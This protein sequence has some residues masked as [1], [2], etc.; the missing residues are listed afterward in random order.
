MTNFIKRVNR[1]RKKR[2]FDNMKYIYVLAVDN[3][4]RPHFHILMSGDGVDR[5]ELEAMWGKCKRPNTRRVKPDEDFG[6]TGLA[7]YISQNPH[8]TKRWCSS[9]NL[10]KPPEPT[11][12]Y[13]KFKKRR[14]EKMAKDHETLKQSL[15]KE[16][17]GYRFLDA[18]V[19]FNTVTAAFY[20]YA[21]MTRD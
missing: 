20:I 7:T 17:A 6:I 19:K 3:Y 1:K 9:K 4:T 15:E 16:Y 2:G 14:V 5:D 10:K 11:R 12:S 21:R 8:G 13:R 18:E